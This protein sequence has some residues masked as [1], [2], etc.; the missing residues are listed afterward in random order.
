MNKVACVKLHKTNKNVAVHFLWHI[1]IACYLF[2]LAFSAI[3]HYSL[4]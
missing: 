3:N 4:G 1:K 2:V